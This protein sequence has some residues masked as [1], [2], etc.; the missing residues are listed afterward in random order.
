MIRRRRSPRPP[1]ADALRPPT[2]NDLHEWVLSLPWVVERPAQSWQPSARCFAVDCA[3]L[4]RRRAWLVTDA[5]WS[6]NTD[7]LRIA[8]VMP[9]V[10][11]ATMASDGW[12]VWAKS[13]RSE[14]VIVL[15][16][17]GST[18]ARTEVEAF[19]LVAYNHALA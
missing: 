17:D 6:A 14:R 11:V 3:P 15:L 8:A 9:A 10:A 5:P 7:A 12:L 19:L 13:L 1:I 2:S 4:N 16:E 18:R